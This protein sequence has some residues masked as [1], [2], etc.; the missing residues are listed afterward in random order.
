MLFCTQHAWGQFNFSS[1]D[2]FVR[3]FEGGGSPNEIRI[4]APD[5]GPFN[6]EVSS[7][8]WFATASQTSQLLAGRIQASCNTGG[9]RG[10]SAVNVTFTLNAPTMMRVVFGVGGD[11][12]AIPEARLTSSGGVSIRASTGGTTNSVDVTQI[13]PVGNYTLSVRSIGGTGGAGAS[14]EALP[15]YSIDWSTIDCGG[16]QLSGGAYTLNTTIAQT[17]STQS[18]QLTGGTFTITGG[19][20][21][22]TAG[23]TGLTC[24]SIDFNNDS[25][26]F[27]PTDIDAFLSVFSEGPCIPEEAT[28]SDIDFN[29][30]GSLFDPCDID[31]FLLVF[32]EGPCTPCGQ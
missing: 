24:D 25:A 17:D 32:S 20:W 30:D 11:G 12:S 2:R 8:L 31:S 3:V 10:E 21:A 4:T 16:G 1:Q 27:D 26:F 13:F 6:E 19:F 7:P 5:F 28:C 23:P 9:V 14:L 18:D 22:I 29:N 15:I